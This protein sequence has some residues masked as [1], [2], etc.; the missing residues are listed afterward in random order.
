MFVLRTLMNT[1]ASDIYISGTDLPIT[2]V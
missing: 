1:S 2:K